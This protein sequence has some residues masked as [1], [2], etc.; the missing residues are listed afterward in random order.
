MSPE[1][2]LGALEVAGKLKDV[3]RHSWTASGRRESTAEH[4]FRLALFAFFIKDEFPEIDADRLIKMCLIHDL[5]EAFTGDIPSFEKTK[6]DEAKEEDVLLGW[7]DSL[8]DP[9]SSEM[10]SLYSEMIEMK[11]DEAR[12]YKALDNLEAVITHNEADLSTW[13]E[14]EYTLNL[15]YGEER[16]AEFPYLAEVRRLVR[17]ITEK[18]IENAARG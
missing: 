12:I 11:T 14:K 15:T 4:T 10:S 18:K 2:L 7:V 9:I 6:G 1:K 5:G 13:I 16:C 17:D 3:T 8:P